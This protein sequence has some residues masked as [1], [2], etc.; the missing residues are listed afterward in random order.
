MAKQ[1]CWLQEHP[2]QDRDS[3]YENYGKMW[4]IATRASH[5]DLTCIM[6]EKPL[7]PDK[8]T[9]AVNNFYSGQIIRENLFRKPKMFINF[10]LFGV[11]MQKQITAIT[12][13]QI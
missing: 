8:K 6:F 11:W 10:T 5:F 7:L 9:Y 13:F 1:G 3:T 12:P 2:K 4:A